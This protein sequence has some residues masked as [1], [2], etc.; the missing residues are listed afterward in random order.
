[1]VDLEVH[2][3]IGAELVR[4]GT[5]WRPARGGETFTYAQEYLEGGGELLSLSLPLSLREFTAGE[6]EPYFEG[7][8]PEG[9]AR[10]ALVGRLAVPA[11]DYLALLE[12]IGLDCIG[13]VVIRPTGVGG[14]EDTTWDGG[15]YKALTGADLKKVVSDLTS[16]AGANESSRV[17]LA[18]T[19]G[20]VGLAHLPSKA[21]DEGWLLPQGG[22]A[23][24]HIVKT[25]SLSRIAEFEVICMGAARRCGLAAP[26]TDV[27]SLGKPVGCIERFDREVLADDRKIVVRRLHQEDLAQAFGMSPRAKYVELDGGTYAAIARMLGEESARP[28]EDIDNLARLVLFNY[29]VGNC[30]NHLKN[31][32]V[33]RRG[34]YV[35]LAPAY[36]IVCTTFFERFSREM[37]A[38]IGSTRT[39]DKVA[40]DDFSLLARDLGIGM[41]RLRTI[42]LELLQQ[43]GQS[44]L[45]AGEEFSDTLETLPYAAE[46]IVDDITPRLKVLT[47]YSK[48]L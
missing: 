18:G 9:P 3:V 38:R 26:R 6:I 10:D 42:S 11:D 21:M 13:D 33:V 30:D 40:S 47:G 20:K 19:Q 2:R 25:S 48:G 1:M 7:L 14:D 39:I 5:I 17:S 43:V 4:V 29:I 35:R 37:G 32:S 34:R 23:S 36:D 22:A 28:V 27:L 45:E 44:L 31:L 15:S 46:D 24:T 41:K 8:L 12:V 16:I